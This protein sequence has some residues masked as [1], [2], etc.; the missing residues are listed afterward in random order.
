[1][2]NKPLPTPDVLRQLLRYEPRT[3]KLFWL[4]RG[5]EWFSGGCRTPE[6]RANNWNARHAGEETGHV[7]PNGYM[8]I[9]L[10]S[11]RISFH[12]VAWA[13]F[14]GCYPPPDKQIDHIDRD[15]SNNRISNLR[16]VSLRENI[17]N[18]SSTRD[19]AIGAYWMPR[20]KKWQSSI[21]WNGKQVYL[22]IFRQREDALQ[23]YTTALDRVSRGLHP[24]HHP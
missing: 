22:G 3:G 9:C 6:W 14:H 17:W 11:R 20:N 18:R 7:L 23:A 16:A 15:K 8:Q 10:F 19:D 12:R 5:P 1:M 13:I 21:G 2:A 4:E 24:R